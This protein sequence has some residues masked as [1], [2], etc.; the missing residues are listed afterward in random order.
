[1]ARDEE[2]KE[3]YRR[4]SV[5]LDDVSTPF[6]WFQSLGLSLHES[7]GLMAKARSVRTF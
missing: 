2:E 4:P 3:T 1:M 5:D 7:V 6:F